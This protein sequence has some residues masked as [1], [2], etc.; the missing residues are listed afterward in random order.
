[1]SLTENPARR[2]ARPGGRR[3]P[4][5]V[6]CP[7]LRSLVLVPGPRSVSPVQSS[8]SQS[9]RLRPEGHLG[10]AR[11]AGRPR[12][13]WPLPAARAVAQ[14]RGRSGG[15]AGRVGR[16]GPSGAPA[17]ATRGSR[18]GPPSPFPSDSG[19]SRGPSPGQPLG[20]L[21]CR[22]G[23]R[24]WGR[25]E[26]HSAPTGQVGRPCGPLFRDPG[27]GQVVT[28]LQ[29]SKNALDS[30]PENAHLG[31]NRPGFKSSAPRPSSYR[32]RELS[33]VENAI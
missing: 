11:R 5:P 33:W 31:R 8:S 2:P 23:G 1:M 15:R 28:R 30:R 18:Y 24:V 13:R 4:S 32:F 12:A 7:R 6:P 3:G 20:A 25:T 14:G 29:A 26:A 9:P 10:P 19:A 17:G 22:L 21:R 27:T 16:R